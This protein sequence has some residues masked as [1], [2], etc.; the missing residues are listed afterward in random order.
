MMEEIKQ[1]GIN[2]YK[3]CFGPERPKTNQ[4]KS[5]QKKLKLKLIEHKTIN[6]YL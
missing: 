5:K 4:N 6:K 1:T 2:H 3:Y